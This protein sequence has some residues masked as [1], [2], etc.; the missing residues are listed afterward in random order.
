VALLEDQDF[1]AGLVKFFA[2]RG[3]GDAA[4]D[5]AQEVST[6]LL[7]APGFPPSKNEIEQVKYAFTTARHLFSAGTQSAR[8]GEK[9]RRG[10]RARRP[11]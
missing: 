5:L 7:T 2:R 11:R 1:R 6:M 8:E 3:A 9:C 10:I 4:E